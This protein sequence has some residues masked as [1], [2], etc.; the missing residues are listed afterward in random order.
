MNNICNY[1]HGKLVSGESKEEL[2]VFDPS[3]GEEISKV[4]LSNSVK[5]NDIVSNMCKD[6]NLKRLNSFSKTVFIITFN[7]YP[8]NLAF[9]IGWNKSSFFSISQ[10]K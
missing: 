1:I 5:Y 10:C 6:L 8:A 3:T 4:I 7:K 2:P 9:S